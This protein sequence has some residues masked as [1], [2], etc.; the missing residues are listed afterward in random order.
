MAGDHI[1]MPLWRDQGAG[2]VAGGAGHMPPPVA[3]MRAVSVDAPGRAI[4]FILVGIGAI[5]VNDMLIKLLSGGYPLHQMVFIRSVIAICASFV[6]LR[7]EGGLRLLRT[8]QAW[9]HVMRAAFIV[10]AN[11]LFFLS[12]SVMPL[13]AATALFFVAPLFITLLAIPVL[14]ETLGRH[15]LTAVA[16]GLVGVVIMVAPGVDWGDVPRWALALP[17]LAAACYAGMQVLTRKLG[18]TASASAM[19]IYIQGAFILVS[20][21]FFLVAGDG[22]F[23]EGRTSEPMQF[24]L[25]AWVWPATEDFWV[26]GL[27]GLLAGAVGYCLSQAY[28]LGRASVVA[29]YE[30]VALPLALFWGWLI[31]G[32]VPRPSVW[33][34]TALIAGAGLYV[35]ARERARDR[36]IASA[37]PIRRV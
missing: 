34:G 3:G 17:M 20:A 1:E 37:R 15:R 8:D 31:F 30:Y 32:E 5:S 33:L 4:L 35:F 7:L 11:M 26:F 23:A 9:L 2:P 24:L 25:R 14:G 12:L 28:R 16:V 6:F 13:G 22:R 19:A 27:L 29:S 36:A 10:L 18:A 21:G